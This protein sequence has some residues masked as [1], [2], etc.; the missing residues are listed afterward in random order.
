MLRGVARSLSIRNCRFTTVASLGGASDRVQTSLLCYFTS[1]HSC[2]SSLGLPASVTFPVVLSGDGGLWHEANFYLFS[3]YKN[4]SIGIETCSDISKDLSL[5]KRYLEDEELSYTYF[6]EEKL[7]RVT[8]R[9]RSS[10]LNKV[11][12]REISSSTAKRRIGA[13]VSFYRWLGENGVFIPENNPWVESE[14]Y[15]IGGDRVGN[16]ILRK[17]KVTDLS[18][19]APK[20]LDTEIIYDGGKLKPIPLDRQIHLLEVLVEAGNPEMLLAHCIALFTG[21]RIQT[22]LTLRAGVFAGEFEDRRHYQ[23]FAGPETGVDTKYGKNITLLFPGWLM[24]RLATYRESPRWA[25]R[26]EKFRSRENRESDYLMMTNRGEPYY[27]SRQDV[28]ASQSRYKS[29]GQAVRQFIYDQVIPR[30]SRNGADVWR[31]QFHDLR[32][33]CGMNIVDAL[34]P[35]V[36]RNEMSLSY[37]REYVRTRLS[38]ESFKTTDLY[39]DYRRLNNLV[40]VAQFDWEEHLKDIADKGLLNFM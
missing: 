28:T 4:G 32:A 10:L 6:P 1:P 26:A 22:V 27:L 33:T 21:A 25:G 14:R 24:S 5:F 18:I 39:L 17:I 7:K 34:M 11:R 30:L 8:Y 2:Y 13:V 37:V 16:K 20:L 23:V 35:R 36:E 15:L 19:K 29:E 38:H 12:S 31:Y 3:R 9:Y 40:A